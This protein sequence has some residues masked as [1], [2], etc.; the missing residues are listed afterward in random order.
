MKS[1]PFGTVAEQARAR[2]GWKKPSQRPEPPMCKNCSHV[3]IRYEDRFP[4]DAEFFRCGKHD[5]AT[6]KGCWCDDFS[7]HFSKG[8]K[9][10]AI[11]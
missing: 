11:Q 5:F 1:D 10:G 2:C 3:D 9:G 8:A 6:E 7:A 4:K